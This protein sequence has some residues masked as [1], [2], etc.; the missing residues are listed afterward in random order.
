VDGALLTYFLPRD[1]GVET[2]V[3]WRAG[4]AVGTFL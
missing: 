2:P 4:G 3:T 1:E